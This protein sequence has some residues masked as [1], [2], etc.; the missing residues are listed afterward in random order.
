MLILV[1]RAPR[2]QKQSTSARHVRQDATPR[3]K[4]SRGR[5]RG[6]HAFIACV[7]NEWV[8]WCGQW[9]GR[10]RRSEGGG[11]RRGRMQRRVDYAMG[12][13]RPLFQMKSC[14]FFQ[15]MQLEK[16]YAVA[17][18]VLRPK[19]RPP[20]HVRAVANARC[21][22]RDLLLPSLSSPSLPFPSS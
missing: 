14:S 21:R 11:G 6:R 20:K 13:S 17:P 1:L 22:P 16:H 8:C 12:H 19:A 18:H 15:I 7:L 4:E 5:E 10:K 9:N 3:V 2:A